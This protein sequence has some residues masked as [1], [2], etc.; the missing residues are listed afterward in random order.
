MVG[1]VRTHHQRDHISSSAAAELKRLRGESSGGHG[2]L[3]KEIARSHQYTLQLER[4][5]RY[6]LTKG[7]EN[8]RTHT[9]THTHTHTNTLA[10]C[11][12]LK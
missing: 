3:S 7:G 9:H 6:Y 2:D 8:A 5:L 12:Q 4:Q 1:Q 10:L 11:V